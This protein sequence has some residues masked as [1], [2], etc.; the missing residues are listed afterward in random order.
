MIVPRR[1]IGAI[2]LAVLALLTLPGELSAARKKSKQ[3][4]PVP[5]QQPKPECGG[6]DMLPEIALSDPALHAKILS[7]A[8]AI[9]NGG[10][11]LWKIERA[12]T[13]ASHLFGTVH[14][15]DQ[16]VALL[17]P[18]TKA[19]LAK[20]ALVAL[21]VADLSPNNSAIAL[22]GAMRLAIFT[23]GTTL[24]TL[25]TA[26]EFA[27][28]RQAVTRAGMPVETA[29]LFKPWI[30]TMLMSGTECERKKIQ[31]GALVQDMRIADIA[32]KR[33]VPLVSLE[34]IDSQLEALATIPQDRQLEMLRS[35]LPYLDR[36]QDL[37]ETTLQFY[38]K[39]NIGAV[40]PFQMA[41]AQKAGF[42]QATF[43]SFQEQLII[44]RNMK[45]RDRALPHLA[46]GGAF[47]AVGAL[48]LPGRSGLVSLFREAGYTVTPVE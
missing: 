16:R 4:E 33:S 14:L 10:A 30:V 22:S 25:I 37:I 12:G 8:A 32:K 17:P 41:L 2:L 46:K 15:T 44:G 7:E 26:D 45:M 1:C 42:D 6:I 11:V 28:V 40:W 27:K 36:T 20:A 39:R 21:E 18:K 19:A 3:V 9:E 38:L 34:T 23:D 5:A 48:H 43:A 31:D 24:E 47:I 13:P 29:R 35:S